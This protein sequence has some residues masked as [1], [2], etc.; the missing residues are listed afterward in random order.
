MLSIGVTHCLQGRGSI[1][2]D[3]FHINP[4]GKHVEN[5]MGNDLSYTKIDMQAQNNY[6]LLSV[7]DFF[8]IPDGV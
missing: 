7:W 1:F 6:I 3:L 5:L 8:E 4:D 2:T